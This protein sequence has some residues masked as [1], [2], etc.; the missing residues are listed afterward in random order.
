MIWPME[1]RPAPYKHNYKLDRLMIPVRRRVRG[2]KRRLRAT[3]EFLQYSTP[4]NWTL[5]GRLW[6]KSRDDVPTPGKFRRR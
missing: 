3:R 6:H 2:R 1:E 5:A 4:P